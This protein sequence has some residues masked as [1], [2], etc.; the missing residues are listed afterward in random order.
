MQTVR[1]P[2]RKPGAGSTVVAGSRIRH[3]TS[4]GT[5]VEEGPYAVQVVVAEADRQ[6]ADGPRDPG[7]HR[8]GPDEP[9]VDGEEGLIGADRDQVA[10]R[11]RPCE[12][13]RRGRH[14]GAVLRE[15]HHLRGRHHLEDRLRAVPLERRWA[16]EV[17]AVS[18]GLR[19]RV[20]DLG[21][22]V[23]EEDGAQPHP[24][25]DELPAVDVPDVGAGSALDQ[26]RRLPGV[27][28]V[29]L[30]VRMRTTRDEQA[31][32]PLE[33]SGAVGYRHGGSGGWGVVAPSGRRHRLHISKLCVR[34][35]S[36]QCIR[37]PHHAPYR[38][39]G[40]GKCADG[41][42]PDRSAYFVSTATTCRDFVTRSHA[43]GRLAPPPPVR[44]ASLHH[45]RRRAKRRPPPWSNP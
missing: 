4:R 35:E 30:G 3:A 19:R 41:P 6:V 17:D 34:Q 29:P 2:S 45:T 31:S 27:L 26:G 36:G 33:L 14:V 38:P 20:H 13:H 21:V 11:P 15:L 1:S 7:R 12:L 8:R 44:V 28:V 43:A 40:R 32:P 18:H 39:R 10:P 25:L 23:P 5:R 24:V 37:L 9:V 16:G 22:A 42:S